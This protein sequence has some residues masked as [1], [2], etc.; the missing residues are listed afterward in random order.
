MYKNAI[1]ENKMIFTK[2]SKISHLPVQD[3][4]FKVSKSLNWQFNL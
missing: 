3:L 1:R 4:Y 2:K